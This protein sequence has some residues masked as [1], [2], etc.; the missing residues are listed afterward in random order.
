ME[1]GAGC[2]EV[3]GTD[4]KHADMVDVSR[5][6]VQNFDRSFGPF[7]LAHCASLV[8]LDRTKAARKHTFDIVNLD[9]V[10]LY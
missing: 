1:N 2:L 9:D 4:G 8:P 6:E 7:R 3:C 10:L 5:Y